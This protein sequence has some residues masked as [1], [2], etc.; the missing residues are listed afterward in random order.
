MKA[1]GANH[2][3]DRGQRVQRRDREEGKARPG[4]RAGRLAQAVREQPC[5]ASSAQP[6]HLRAARPQH[7][8][9]PPAHACSRACASALQPGAALPPG[10]ARGTSPERPWPLGPE[11]HRPRPG[12]GPSLCTPVAPAAPPASCAGTPRPGAEVPTPPPAAPPP[13]GPSSSHQTA[14]WPAASAPA[15]SALTV[16]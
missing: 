16:G 14:A 6:A 8:T 5:A 9:S 4:S 2:S 12:L 11:P 7:W 1:T 10:S 15:L 13:C 3:A